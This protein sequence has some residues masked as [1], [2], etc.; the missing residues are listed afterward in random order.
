[1]SCCDT[2]SHVC[3]LQLLVPYLGDAIVVI[4]GLALVML[5]V[6]VAGNASC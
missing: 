3:I 4:I 2:L 5:L 1:M 6:G